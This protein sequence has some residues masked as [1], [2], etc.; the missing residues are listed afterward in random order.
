MKQFTINGH[1]C[2][3]GQSAI[4]NWRLLDDSDPD[5][6]FMHL[7]SFSSGYIILNCSEPDNDTLIEAAKLCIA[8]TKYKNLRNLKVDYCKCSNLTKGSKTGEV[9]FTRP[10]LV[11]QVQI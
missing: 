4:E 7:A 2:R 6:Y 1:L 11:K 3:L 10:K 5:D 8:G 9:I